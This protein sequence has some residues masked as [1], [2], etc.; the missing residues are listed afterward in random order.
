MSG[1]V[2]PTMAILGQ[3]LDGL[4]SK[5]SV[6]SSNLANIDTPNYQP[7]TVDFETTLQNELAG[8]SSSF[9]T[10]LPPSGS[11]SADVAM[12]TN[13]ARQFSSLGSSA[14]TSTANV[15]ATSENLRNDRNQV[16]LE[17]EMTALT[18]TQIKYEADSR[19]MAGKFTMLYDVLGGH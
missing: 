7:K 4:T 13:N 10:A 11:P 2:D 14:G 8:Q 16:D 9:S 6:I 1:L 17:T 12:K 15:A 18:E 5:Q 19:L 3:A